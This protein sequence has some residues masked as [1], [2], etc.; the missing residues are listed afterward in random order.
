MATRSTRLIVPVKFDEWI[1]GLE[2]FD[3][4][5]E[6]L[7]EWTDATE[8]FYAASQEHVH[9]I[10][11]ALRTSGRHDTEHTGRGR[12]TGTLTYGGTQV[13][14]SGHDRP[15]TVDYA[16]YEQRRGGDH[17]W[18]AKAFAQTRRDFTRALEAGIDS[19]VRGFI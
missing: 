13:T 16:V 5:D 18:I 11:N 6:I 2:H 8:R 17:D 7:H 1:E 3:P 14:V 19:H 12:V 9:V 10:T 4:G 15:R